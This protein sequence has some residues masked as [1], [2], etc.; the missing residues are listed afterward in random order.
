LHGIPR[1]GNNHTFPA[2]A[3]TT[4]T[5]YWISLATVPLILFCIAVLVIVAITGRLACCRKV[6]RPAVAHTAP[7]WWGIILF[8]CVTLA[9]I[10]LAGAQYGRYIDAGLTDADNSVDSAR[11]ISITAKN[12]A[13]SLDKDGLTLSQLFLDLNSTCFE[14]VAGAAQYL[15]SAAKSVVSYSAQMDIYTD[16]IQALPDQIGEFKPFAR[17]MRT[18][19]AAGMGGP[20]VACVIPCCC[21]LFAF[22]FSILTCAYG[23]C[24]VVLLRVAIWWT[25]LAVA[26]ATGIGAAELAFATGSGDFCSDATANTMGLVSS[27]FGPSS[28][29]SNITSYYLTGLG[30]NVL[31]DSLQ[32]GNQSIAAFSQDLTNAKPSLVAQCP[33]WDR[34]TDIDAA[35]SSVHRSIGDLDV[36]LS[37]SRVYP[38][39]YGA[40]VSFCNKVVVGIVWMVGVQLVVSFFVLPPFTLTANYFLL[41]R[42]S[43]AE[44]NAAQPLVQGYAGGVGVQV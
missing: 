31:T 3:V 29:A 32:Q 9:L 8:V 5:I 21:V 15:D 23:S 43:F 38:L 35:V 6:I 25:L 2:D 22:C 17:D 16:K 14:K 7:T 37:G 33:S 4:D 26:L 36:V 12:A 13:D 24:E 1:I 30:V 28:T 34:Y 20:L 40:Q 19:M 42:K 11:D 27:A 10:S 39:Y 44:I 18:W 41:R